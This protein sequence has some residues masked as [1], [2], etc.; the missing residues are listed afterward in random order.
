MLGGCKS[1]QGG[2]RE[3]GLKTFPQ[4]TFIL[5]HQSR[6]REKGREKKERKKKGGKVE[7]LGEEDSAFFFGED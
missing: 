6:V 1:S 3:R 2:E 7:P 4:K 5:L